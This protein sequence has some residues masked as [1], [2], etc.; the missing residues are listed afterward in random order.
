MLI[1]AAGTRQKEEC[2]HNGKSCNG[3]ILRPIGFL[4]VAIIIFSSFYLYIYDR[5]KA[6]LSEQKQLAGLIFKRG[7]ICSVP[8]PIAIGVIKKFNGTLEIITDNNLSSRYPF[9]Q[10][11][12]MLEWGIPRIRIGKNDYILNE[13]KEVFSIPTK[14]EPSAVLYVSEKRDAK[15]SATDIIIK[16]VEHPSQ[17]IIFDEIWE[18]E[19]YSVSVN[20]YCPN[21]RSFPTPEQ[22]PRKI[23][24]D[25]LGF[26]SNIPKTSLETPKIT[27]S[28]NKY[29]SAEIVSITKGGETHDM[30]RRRLKYDFYKE[31]K[32]LYHHLRFNQNCPPGTGWD[33]LSSLDKLTMGWPFMINGKAY[34]PGKQEHYN[35][36][37]SDDY[38]YLYYVATSSSNFH[39]IIRKRTL[40]DFQELWSYSI[41]FPKS[42]SEDARYKSFKIKSIKNTD[43]QYLIK[44]T[45]QHSGAIITLKADLN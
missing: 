23:L 29:I 11:K 6:N 28:R 1:V 24:M 43:S 13:Y 10:I 19:P 31:N 7:K 22:Q 36:I 20:I 33:G 30:E 25:A 45:D 9:R 44:L 18:K 37:C 40:S 41:S 12:R 21:Y 35:S 14:D 5:E 34:Y 2:G 39:L 26:N 3:L 8:D 16:L 32:R 4:L 17:R 27:T 38:V 42:I 15:G